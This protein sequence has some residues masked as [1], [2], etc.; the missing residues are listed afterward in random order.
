MA[1]IESTDVKFHFVDKDNGEYVIVLDTPLTFY[2]NG[3]AYVIEKGYES[4]GMSVPRCLWSVISPQYSPRTLFPSIV[5]DWL[6]GHYVM[7]RDEA[8]KWY[9]EALLERGYPVWKT[10]LV[11]DAVR[12]FGRSHWKCE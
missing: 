5:H 12:M 1:H 8:D 4:N 2:A 7:P 6:Y 11:Y 9:R 3:T 10:T